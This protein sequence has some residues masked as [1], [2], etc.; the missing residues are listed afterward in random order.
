MNLVAEGLNV[1]LVSFPSWELFAKQDRKYQETVLPPQVRTRIA[2][3]AGVTMG[4]SRWTGGRGLVIG[5]DAF[6]ASAPYE[7]LYE[8]F[9][10]SVTAITQ[11]VERLVRENQ[12]DDLSSLGR[13]SWMG[14]EE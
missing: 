11:Q 13:Y 9:G 8:E 12:V 14:G 3:E 10:L 4:W 6:G 5:L 1:R 2:V 7:T